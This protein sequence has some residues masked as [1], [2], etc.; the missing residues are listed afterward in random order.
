MIIDTDKLLLDDGTPVFE[1]HPQLKKRWTVEQL[2]NYAEH[3][4]RK[5]QIQYEEECEKISEIEWII[6]EAKKVQVFGM[7]PAH[8][9]VEKS[10][11]VY[12]PFIGKVL[13]DDKLIYNGRLYLKDQF[14][15]YDDFWLKIPKHCWGIWHDGA[16]R[17]FDAEHN[18]ENIFVYLSDK[19]IQIRNFR[20]EANAIYR[21][22]ED[23]LKRLEYMD[24]VK[25]EDNNE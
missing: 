14:D 11:E 15:P 2:E 24:K 21:I 12:Y 7:L 18:L 13:C 23:D 8:R 10:E 3:L 1:R 22:I 25:K 6:S 9:I 4:A 19:T 5:K 17:I 20:E 16:S